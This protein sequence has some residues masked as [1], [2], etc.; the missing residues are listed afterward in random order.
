[1]GLVL[2]IISELTIFME[3]YMGIKENIEQFLNDNMKIS[4]KVFS[5]EY[6]TIE[7]FINGT[8]DL[9]NRCRIVRIIKK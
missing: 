4:V 9:F 2:E 8:F 3:D 6:L 7:D 5:S 1:L